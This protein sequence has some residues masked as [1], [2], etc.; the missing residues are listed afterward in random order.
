MIEI[1]EELGF[2]VKS[3]FFK[4]NI[5]NCAT[6]L[7]IF[8]SIAKKDIVLLNDLRTL[9]IEKKYFQHLNNTLKRS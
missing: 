9:K 6:L 7:Y 3:V 2:Y 4:F 5:N 8:F 1:H